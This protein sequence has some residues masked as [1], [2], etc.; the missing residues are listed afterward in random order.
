MD[1]GGGDGCS[2]EAS[3]FTCW[4]RRRMNSRKAA[5]CS[6]LSSSPNWSSSFWKW[7]WLPNSLSAAA[8]SRY[9]PHRNR[10]IY[11]AWYHPN[12]R[13]TFWISEESQLSSSKTGIVRKVAKAQLFD[14]W[15]ENVPRYPIH[16]HPK[17]DKGHQTRPE[18]QSHPDTHRIMIMTFLRFDLTTSIVNYFLVSRRVNLHVWR[19]HFERIE[20]LRRPWFSILE[21][22]EILE[23]YF[24]RDVRWCTEVL[25]WPS[26]FF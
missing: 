25:T 18:Q 10:N 21:E 11:E 26:F 15:V 4:I 9:L 19:G 14:P 20:K 6:R 13:L 2:K 3:F 7:L 16:W 8:P 1:R 12:R 23:L 5:S 22:R 24:D 17:S